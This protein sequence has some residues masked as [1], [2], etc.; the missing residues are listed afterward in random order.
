MVKW[1]QWDTSPCCQ[2]P[3]VQS[4]FAV[5]HWAFGISYVLE[6]ELKFVLTLFLLQ[7][8]NTHIYIYIYITMFSLCIMFTATCFDTSFSSSGSFKTCTSLSYVSPRCI[9]PGRA[10]TQILFYSKLRK[11]LELKHCNSIKLLD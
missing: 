6:M 10:W 11:L 4:Y 2:K 5:A 8:T 7:P 1:M 3:A 9:G